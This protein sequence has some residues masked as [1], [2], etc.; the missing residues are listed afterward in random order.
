MVKIEDKKIREELLNKTWIN[1][2]EKFPNWK[3]NKILRKNKSGK[4]FYMKTINKVT[5]KIYCKIFRGF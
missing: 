4:D 3:K 2:N 5:Y 1:L